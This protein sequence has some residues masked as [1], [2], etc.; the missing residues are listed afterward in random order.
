MIAL[1]DHGPSMEGAPHSGYF[2]MAD[3]MPRWVS[4]VEVLYGCEANILNAQGELDL[5]H[6]LASYQ[7]LI[8]AGIHARTPY[9]DTSEAKR[10]TEALLSAV[11]NPNIHILA[12]P[13][14]PDVPINIVEVVRA[15]CEAGTMLEINVSTIRSIIARV[16]SVES[17]HSTLA[18]MRTLVESVERYGGRYVV[19]SDCHHTSEIGVSV[20]VEKWLLDVLGLND[21]L[22]ANRSRESVYANF[23]HLGTR[24]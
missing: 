3:R 14:R 13:I 16:H 19:S 15:A 5:D 8:V 24:V 22:I 11:N 20:G 9:G 17:A 7:H 21:S 10:N 6:E 1:T 4:G 2:T 18:D 23:P 12:H